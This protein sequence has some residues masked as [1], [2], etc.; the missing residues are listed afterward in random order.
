MA[1]RSRSKRRRRGLLFAAVGVLVA[2]A[3]GLG[4]GLG[5]RWRYDILSNKRCSRYWGPDFTSTVRV[6]AQVLTLTQLAVTLNVIYGPI[7]A[8]WSY[9]IPQ[10]RCQDP[11]LH[12]K[13]G[14]VDRSIRLSQI[15]SVPPTL[16]SL[17]M[18]RNGST[19]VGHG[20]ELSSS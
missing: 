9:S 20:K 17:A 10:H 8:P 14:E 12:R 3:A 4:G 6:A 15:D 11:M 1:L 7:P 19:A 13:T 16:P 5:V 2:L 18:L